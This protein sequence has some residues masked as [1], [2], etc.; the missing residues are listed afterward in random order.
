MSDSSELQKELETRDTPIFPAHA[1]RLEPVLTLRTGLLYVV[2]IAV[3]AYWT[4]YSEGVVSATSFHSL[5]PPINI[6]VVLFLMA[7]A[8]VPFHW[9][10]K[11][12]HWGA[13]VVLFLLL[14]PGIR[15][16]YALLLLLAGNVFP[17]V[18]ETIPAMS[19]PVSI[20]VALALFFPL[21]WSLERSTPLNTRE[22]IAVY[23]MLMVGTLCTGYAV[24]QFLTP[25]LVSARYFKTPENRWEEL[26]FQHLPPWFGLSK[27]APIKAFWIGGTD[28]VFWE[29]WLRP[30]F[31]WLVFALVAMWVMFCLCALVQKQWIDYERLTFP[32]V[33]MPLELAR[34]EE[35]HHWGPLYRNP[36]LWIG[37]AFPVVLHLFNGLNSYYPAVPTLNFRH[38]NL[39]QGI[40]TPPWNSIGGLDITF[41][42]LLIGFTYLLTLD[43]SF[44]VWFFF[45]LRKLEP[46]L[47]MS[48]GW[49][50]ILSPSSKVFPF[51]DQQSTGAFAA[52]AVMALWTGRRSFAATVRNAWRPTQAREP[53]APLTDREIVLGIVGGMIFLCGWSWYA[54]LGV[55]WAIGFFV[56]FFIWCVTLSRIRAEAG[57]GGLTGPLTP[58]ETLVMFAGSQAI[59][60]QSLTV[61]AYFRWFTTDLR[62]L[63]SIM[64]AQ[65]ED[66]RMSRAVG[67]S[68]RSLA[69]AVMFA[70]FVASVFAFIIYI[71]II[72][73]Y[74]GVNMNGQRFL[75]VPVFP[76]RELSSLI[77]SPKPPD[78]VTSLATAFGFV[79]SAVLSVLRL[80]FAWFPFHPIGYAVGFSRRTI[81]WM[82]FS[83]FLGWLIKLLILRSGGLGTYRRFLPLFLGFI[84]GEFTMGVIYG[85][86]GTV[87]PAARGY[88]LY[89]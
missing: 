47:G 52:I 88:Q 35:G 36:V 49:H 57:L 80:R 66:I 4:S 18:R 73:R 26:F 82:W 68:T 13:R 77:S 23:S 40:Q 45:L 63:A 42:P 27:S 76:F 60:P 65:L 61:L 17:A 51:T 28:Q 33:F 34:T 89:P 12:K 15:A 86:V 54:G 74:G 55:G 78:W 5:S 37:F 44:S 30:L 64:P 11:S 83:V 16:L 22:M 72:Y 43:L 14:V 38:I 87:N 81:E 21:L 32:L 71:P 19:I 31:L 20:L 25:T 84:L 59:G 3:L 29:L 69:W 41:Y 48:L 58:Q 67:L 2:I 46:V 85:I 1:P 56:I 6:T 39:T 8:I 75:D 7:A 50:E 79:F 62:S 70:A 53:E 10:I 24:V 9:W